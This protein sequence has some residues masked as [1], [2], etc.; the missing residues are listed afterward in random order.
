MSSQTVSTSSSNPARSSATATSALKSDGREG[1]SKEVRRVRFNA[2]PKE[3]ST[4]TSENFSQIPIAAKKQAS[5]GRGTSAQTASAKSDYL[6]GKDGGYAVKAKAAAEKAQEEAGNLHKNLES[7]VSAVCSGRTLNLQVELPPD[8]A[9]ELGVALATETISDRSRC[10]TGT[11]HR[12]TGRDDSDE[13]SDFG[14][15]GDPPENWKFNF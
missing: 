3:P 1:S 9:D 5:S 7:G 10:S 11:L 4:E 12:G 13:D 8:H 15:A 6:S 14:A 2:S